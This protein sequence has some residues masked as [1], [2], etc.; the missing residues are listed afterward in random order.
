MIKSW[1]TKHPLVVMMATGIVLALLPS[2]AEY[3]QL[4]IPQPFLTLIERL[5]DAFLVAA[6]LWVLVERAEHEKFLGKFLGESAKT[7]LFDFLG[8]RLPETL[9]DH[10]KDYF[11]FFLVRTKWEIEYWITLQDGTDDHL[12]LITRSKYVMH[13]YSAELKM[14]EFIYEV[15]E[16]A[17]G[18]SATITEVCVSDKGQDVLETWKCENPDRKYVGAQLQGMIKREERYLKLMSPF[19]AEKPFLEPLPPGAEKSF[20][21]TSVECFHK[22]L[23]SPFWTAYAVLNATFKVFYDPARV[24]VNFDITDEKA[25]EG[26][27]FT[28]KDGHAGRQWQTTQPIL[29]GQGFFVRAVL[30]P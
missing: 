15:E 18:H 29:P 12:R 22:L 9:R 28:D 25:G 13:N 20:S 2:L 8:K 10:I 26:T 7:L 24:V 4:P 19:T 17:C 1:L 11:R 23:V 14:Y 21:A 6:A 16:S 5:G 30:R 3:Y 27:A